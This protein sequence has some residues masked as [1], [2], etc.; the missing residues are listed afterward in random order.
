M[1]LGEGVTRQEVATLAEVCSQQHLVQVRISRLTVL[2][3]SHRVLNTPT[4]HSLISCSTLNHIYVTESCFEQLFSTLNEATTSS[5][6]SLWFSCEF[7]STL[8]HPII[9]VFSRMPRMES[10]LLATSQRASILGAK[11]LKLATQFLMIRSFCLLRQEALIHKDL[12]HSLAAFLKSVSETLE[13][14]Q[15]RRWSLTSTDLDS[16]LQCSNLRVLC[17]TEECGDIVPHYPLLS[18]ADIFIALSQLPAL[19]FFQWSENINMSTAGLLSLHN[20]LTLSLQ[21][22]KH[23]HISLSFILLSTTDLHN[24]EYCILRTIL[25]PLLTGKTGDESC[26]TYRFPFNNEAVEEWL[27]HLRPAV[28]FRLGRQAECVTQLHQSATMGS[29]VY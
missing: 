9:P 6:P 21:S 10:L 2:G 23:F 19:E 18:V 11:L 3:L 14:L 4:L 26:T 12:R 25:E 20:L 16:V 29:Y 27:C 8:N 28:C 5:L 22:L 15:L 24:E 13:Y 1:V 7:Q 17:V